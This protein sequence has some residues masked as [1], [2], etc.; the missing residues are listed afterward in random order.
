M[1]YHKWNCKFNKPVQY[2]L[3][4]KN[5]INRFEIVELVRWT[6]NSLSYLSETR[7]DNV[8]ENRSKSSSMYIEL[9]GPA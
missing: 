3:M 5:K 2:S 1:W 8:F 4:Y 6:K 9:L 7:I